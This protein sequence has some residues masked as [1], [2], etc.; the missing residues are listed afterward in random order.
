MT[1]LQTELLR[2]AGAL[3]ALALRLVGAAD[4]D[5]LVQET[6]L[7]VWAEPPREVHGLGGWLRA[8]LRHRAGKLRRAAGRRRSRESVVARVDAANDAA[9]DVGDVAA[10]RETVQRLH[11]ALMALPEPYQA[12]L[13]QRFFQDLTPTAIALATGVPLA[14]VKSQLQRGLALLR[15]RLERDGDTRDWRA[16]LAMAFALPRRAVVTSA[17]ATSGILLMS[18]F[19][20]LAGGVAAAAVLLFTFWPDAAPSL[21]TAPANAASP[22]PTV[23]VASITEPDPRA[24]DGELR[25]AVAS[26]PA[27]T[28]PLAAAAADV[29]V[30]IV[31]AD[32]GAPLP[33]FAV[34][35]VRNPDQPEASEPVISDAR[36]ELTLPGECRSGALVLNG[37]DHAD[38]PSSQWHTIAADAW[39]APGERLDVPFAVGPTYRLAFASP[40]P[41]GTLSAALTSGDPRHGIGGDSGWVR[42]G[43]MPWVRLDALAT[44]P[45]QL[46]DGPW[47][48]VVSGGDP[49]WY[50]HGRVTTIRGEQAE[51]VQLLDVRGGAL[52]VVVTTNGAPLTSGGY[53]ASVFTLGDD[54]KPVGIDF[55]THLTAGRSSCS[56]ARLPPGKYR[57]FLN[58]PGEQQHRDDVVVVAGEARDVAHDFP[59]AVA[60]H[61]LEVIA[62]SETGTRQLFVLSFSAHQVGGKGITSPVPL[63]VGNRGEQHYRFEDLADGEWDIRLEPTP[64]LPPWRTMVQR[65]AAT[66]GIVTFV[67]LD[68]GAP[69]EGR[70]VIDVTDDKTSKPIAGACVTSF[71]DG[72]QH[73][74][75]MTDLNG[76][77]HESPYMSGVPIK[78]LVCAANCLPAFVTAVPSLELDPEPV[79]VALQPGWGTMLVV[80]RPDP[81]SFRGAMLPGVRV[82]LDGVLAGVTDEQGLLLLGSST[83]PRRID[84]QHDQ[85]VIDYGSIDPVTG[86]P[87]ANTAY[88]FFVVMKPKP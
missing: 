23:A 46:G 35:V 71:V 15:E 68:R 13:L 10:Q 51:P 60:T 39:P 18:T 56:F 32:G 19:T 37:L 25:R 49:F 21:P 24:A 66:A 70:V 82:L 62:R 79:R 17:V 48:L 16:G 85:F 38:H 42:N 22:A 29:R 2:H 7:L 12:V 76:R 26:P 34:R 78:V 9:G 86:A 45:S 36:G 81:D 47:H 75:T 84:L 28:P 3:R 54:G 27:A 77:A 87:D 41:T 74:G 55:T 64:H 4:A 1:E 43:P 11:A 80:R 14:T 6:S 44:S 83:R 31:A 8:V 5:D 69:P 58:G 33:N 63:S 72:N 52:R 67:C 88:A 73:V 40:P 50:A 57:V 20:K 61:A 30:R 53:Y 65:V 59:A